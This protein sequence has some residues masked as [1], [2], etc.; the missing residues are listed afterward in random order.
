M[1]KNLVVAETANDEQLLDQLV[2]DLFLE[3]LRRELVGQKRSIDDSNDK[4]F[5]LDRKIVAEFKKLTGPLETISDTLG[6]QTREL[7]DAKDDA[8]RH[9]L[10]LLNSLAQNMADTTTLYDM[11]QQQNNKNH[12][13]Q[14][15]QL[16]RIHE[17]LLQQSAKL[18]EQNT[19]LI[20]LKEQHVA[21]SHQQEAL[22]EQ[23]FSA[24]LAEM[25]AQNET[26]ESLTEQNKSLHQQMLTLEVKQHAELQTNRRWGKLAMG[27]TLVNTL[28]LVG[29]TTLFFIQH[30][31]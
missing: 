23:L 24:T 8:Q 3:H 31:V 6:E 2:Q 5:N 1:N 30:G 19:A 25:K 9:Y 28:I 12:Q 7:N 18:Q 11:F 20:V 10:T 21:L 26:L 14:V 22:Q 15:E 16:Q 13:E 17:Q 29:M 4:L 27:F